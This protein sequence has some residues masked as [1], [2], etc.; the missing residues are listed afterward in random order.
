[1]ADETA[2]EKPLAIE[3]P[4]PEKPKRKSPML[5]IIV[6]VVLCI[7]MGGAAFLLLTPMGKKIIGGHHADNSKT[8]TLPESIVYYPI[9]ELMVNL[10]PSGKKTHF[11]RLTIKLELPNNDAVKVLDLLKPRVID[12]LQTYLRELRMDDV[13]GSAGLGRLREELL[14]RIN[15]VT[16]PLKINNVLFESLLVQ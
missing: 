12:Q 16:D 9:Q 10:I 11:L 3:G 15:L 2:P 13:E 14:K 6:G 1:M 4:G 5:M 8:K 7:L